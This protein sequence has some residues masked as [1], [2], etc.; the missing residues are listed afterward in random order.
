MYVACKL[1][2]PDFARPSVGFTRTH[3]REIENKEGSKGE[4]DGVL[5]VPT[6]LSLVPK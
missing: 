2:F 5:G 6:R 4:K 3:A 1:G